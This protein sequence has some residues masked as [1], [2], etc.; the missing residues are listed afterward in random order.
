MQSMIKAIFSFTAISLLSLSTFYGTSFGEKI[1]ISEAVGLARLY[2]GEEKQAKDDA[3]RD[4]MK[5]AIEQGMGAVLSSE[6]EIKNFQVVS[7]RI[8]KK[9]GGSI[10]SYKILREG[11]VDE[12]K[13]YE[14]AISAVID[15]DK[16]KESTKE[17]RLMQEMT[18]MKSLFVAYNPNVQ[19]TFK[20]DPKTNKMSIIETAVD[21]MVQGFVDRRFD[22]IDPEISKG[23]IL[24]D[25]SS[26]D[27]MEAEFI[28][29]TSEK[30]TKYGAQ[31]Y[32]IFT[33]EASRTKG[34]ISIAQATINAKMYNIGAATVLKRIEGNGK[35]KFRVKANMDVINAMKAAVKKATL[36]VLTTNSKRLGLVDTLVKR[37]YDYA[38]DGSPLE[39]RFLSE[40]KKFKRPLKNMLKKLDGVKRAGNVRG[41]STDFTVRVYYAGLDTDELL[42]KMEKAF[43]KNRK[44]KGYDI[45]AAIHGERILVSIKEE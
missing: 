26:A 38:E 41:T 4:A 40:N 36:D 34:D 44:F 12:G 37:L 23:N 30:S 6:T 15:N 10:A 2:S 11:E 3:L 1:E 17:F 27:V 35:K 19:G 29:N 20:L 9:S 25:E 31:Y 5:K 16:L 21:N 32:I 39:I 8:Y 42:E 45:E 18:G 14:V 24:D 22:V 33:V 13:H 43:F 28:E 7:D